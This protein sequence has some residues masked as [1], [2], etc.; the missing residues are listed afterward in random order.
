MSTVEKNTR[1][2]ER[3]CVFDRM[4]RHYNVYHCSTVCLELL[5]LY[6][7]RYIESFFSNAATVSASGLNA[8]V[9]VAGGPPFTLVS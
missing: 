9:S 4:P 1:V 8:D 5:D 6:L 3:G 7:C 2:V